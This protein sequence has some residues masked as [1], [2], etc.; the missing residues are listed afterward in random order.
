MVD[1]SNV[2]GFEWDSG[3][4]T[5]NA[6]HRVT[7]RHAEEIF[8]NAPLWITDDVAHS[9]TEERARAIGVTNEGPVLVVAFTL[10]GD[11]TRIRVISARTA[12]RRERMEYESL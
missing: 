4:E 9:T 12:S 6:K 8:S 5:K 11:G 2:T 7:C 1:L 10:R 3:N